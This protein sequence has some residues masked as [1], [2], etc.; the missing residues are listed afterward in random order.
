MRKSCR[1]ISSVSQ[2]DCSDLNYD[3]L[4]ADPWPATCRRQA[5]CSEQ[6]EPLPILE[7]VQL[8]WY[9]KWT[10]IAITLIVGIA[11]WVWVNQQTPVYRAQSTIMLGSPMG[12]TSPEMMWV[13]YFNKLKA[14]DEIEVLKSRS[15]AEQLVESL[16]LLAYPEFN[17]SLREAEPGL[18][19]DINP[20]EWLPDSWKETAQAALDRQ[21]QKEGQDRAIE[22]DLEQRRL[23]R[24]ADYPGRAGHHQPGH[25]QR[26]RG[27]LP[28]HQSENRRTDRQRTARG[29]H[30]FHAA[31][32]VRGH[33]ESHQVAQ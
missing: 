27:G 12:I 7:Y 14:P 10:I 30:A 17:P 29:L 32:Q 5:G 21:P 1:A 20:S 16:D 13:A 9:R 22:Q 3:P 2:N 19:D 8:L 26:D 6:E 25:V 31:G 24:A 18:L 11:G 23:T 28:L 33:R 4:Q 15:L